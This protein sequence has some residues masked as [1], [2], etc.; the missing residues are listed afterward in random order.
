MCSSFILMN[1]I[2]VDRQLQSNISQ[3][4]YSVGRTG[5][6]VWCDVTQGTYEG[7]RKVIIYYKAESLIKPDFLPYEGSD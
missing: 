2:E 3:V 1:S 7:I 5:R 4:T 6:A